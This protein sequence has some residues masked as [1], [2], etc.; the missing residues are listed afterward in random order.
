MNTLSNSNDKKKNNELK[1]VQEKG[2]S[3][4]KTRK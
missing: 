3:N 2:N 1:I 4:D